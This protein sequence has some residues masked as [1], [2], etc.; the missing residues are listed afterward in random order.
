MN[1]P[2]SARKDG[3]HFIY[4][5]APDVCWTPMGSGKVAVPYNSIA[6]L[7]P[8]AR[9]SRTVRNNSDP[10]FQLN[11]RAT[12]TI[13]HEPGTLKGVKVPGY[14]SISHVRVAE[15]TIYSEGWAI[16][17]DG[18]PAWVNRPDYGA[19]EPRRQKSTETIPHA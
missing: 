17:R 5:I 6:F 19:V 7:D 2:I 8:A 3:T 18:D 10:D 14:K 9:V 16:V 13:G 1:V 12:V 11:S 15:R 4:S